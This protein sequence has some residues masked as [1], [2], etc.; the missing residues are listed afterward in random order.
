MAGMVSERDAERADAAALADRARV[1]IGARIFAH[2]DDLC[3]GIEVL[4]RTGERN[5]GELHAGIVTL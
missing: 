5:A 2:M 1:H 3:A 4:P